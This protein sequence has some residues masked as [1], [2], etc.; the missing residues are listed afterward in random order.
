MSGP[1]DVVLEDERWHGLDAWA[2]RGCRAALR[3]RSLDPDAYEIAVLGTDDVRVAA[4][5]GQFR[6]RPSPTNVLS[7]PSEERAPAGDGATP[8]PPEGAELGDIA[9]AWETCSREAEQLGRRFGDHVTHLLVHGTLHLLGYD[10]E[11]EADA[12]LM[13]RT[14]TEILAALDIADPYR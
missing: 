13:E 12:A 4:L 11:T 1:V 10:H 7:W 8:A 14:E 6:G 2:D 9:L 5:N 3:H